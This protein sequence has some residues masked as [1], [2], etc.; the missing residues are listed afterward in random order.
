MKKS[1]KTKKKQGRYRSLCWGLTTKESPIHMQWLLF[2]SGMPSW[3][4]CQTRSCWSQKQLE[5]YSACV[6]II[7]DTKPRARVDTVDIKI[8]GREEIQERHTLCKT[9]LDR[10]RAK[11]AR[12]YRSDD[13][14]PKEVI[15]SG[16]FVYWWRRKP[17][18][19]YR[20]WRCSREDNTH[21]YFF[22]V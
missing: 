18:F 22:F 1:K 9:R 10:N 3:C 15:P 8:N 19:T 7:P 17:T 2:M 21:V 20:F 13:V 4:R 11:I 6:C 16:Y 5:H 12:K 14:V